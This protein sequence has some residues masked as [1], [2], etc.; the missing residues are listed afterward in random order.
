M[1]PISAIINEAQNLR[2]DMSWAWN[3][4]TKWLLRTKAIPI[5][6]RI[7]QSSSAKLLFAVDGVI[8]TETHNWKLYREWEI[9]KYSALNWMFYHNPSFKTQRSVWKKKSMWKKIV[10]ARGGR[11]L[12]GNDVFHTQQ[13]WYTWTHRG[14]DTYTRPAQVQPRQKSNTK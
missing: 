12:Q 9:L 6:H 7:T 4:A 13:G 2:L 11:Q 14:C 3:T 8:N 5:N 1:E 10:R